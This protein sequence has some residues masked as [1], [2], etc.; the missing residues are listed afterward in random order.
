M[1]IHLQKEIEKLKTMILSMSARVEKNF[2]DIAEAVVKVDVE[3]AQRIIREEKEINSI[4]LEVE[5]ECLK[6]LALY[7]PVAVDLR[8]IVAILKINNELERINDFSVNA[9]ERVL[10]LSGLAMESSPFDIR[11]MA[12]KVGRMLSMSLDALINMDPQMAVEVCNLDDQV[13]EINKTIFQQVIAQLKAGS[14]QVEMLL[15]FSSI[16]R[17]LER[18]ADLASNIAEDVVYLVEGEIV[19]HQNLE[20]YD[21]HKG[22]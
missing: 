19:R 9:A 11:G 17:Y 14:P 6:C 13:D 2:H 12:D 20:G 18:I 5:E 16:S 10:D 21:F 15:L 8:L 1:T 4:E 22:R 3:T 7:Q